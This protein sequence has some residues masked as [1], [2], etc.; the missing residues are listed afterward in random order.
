MHVREQLQDCACMRR[1]SRDGSA[2]PTKAAHSS[3]PAMLLGV[4]PPLCSG[5]VL[6]CCLLLGFAF[7]AASCNSLFV[8][9]RQWGHILLQ[10]GF[11]GGFAR[12]FAAVALPHNV[13]GVHKPCCHANG[14]G[15]LCLQ[16]ARSHCKCVCRDIPKL[17]WADPD[18]QAVSSAEHQSVSVVK[19]EIVAIL[20]RNPYCQNAS[21]PS[22][23]LRY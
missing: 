9:R 15:C 7:G 17:F 3:R 23:R 8:A 5:S 13:L 16:A 19:V 21:E 1:R 11:A 22:V 6:C 4:L 10:P 20:Y 2:A 12:V 18:V 14:V